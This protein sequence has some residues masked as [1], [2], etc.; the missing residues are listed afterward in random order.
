MLAKMYVAGRRSSN[1]GWESLICSKICSC[2][3][4]SPWSVVYDFTMIVFN[5]WSYYDVWCSHD[6][7]YSWFLHGFFRCFSMFPYV[8]WN[9]CSFWRCCD[10]SS[11]VFCLN[12]FFFNGVSLRFHMVS[13]FP[14]MLW[15][16]EDC[17]K[18]VRIVVWWFLLDGLHNLLIFQ[19]FVLQWNHSF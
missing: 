1:C 14:E 18:I 16:F 15:L 8:L 11:Y 6:F 7:T 4:I 2:F 13:C 3:L 19:C 12:L 17:L 5:R 9:V 10:V